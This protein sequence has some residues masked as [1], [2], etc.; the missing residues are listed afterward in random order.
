MALESMPGGR[1]DTLALALELFLQSPSI[2][3]FSSQLWAARRVK[4]SGS[5]R[6]GVINQYLR[7][8]DMRHQ[9]RGRVTPMISS[10]IMGP[11]IL[12]VSSMGS[13]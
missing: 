13:Y 8:F 10:T 7:T 6:D 9:T 2:A 5:P 12:Q 11:L 4:R 1:K 3:P